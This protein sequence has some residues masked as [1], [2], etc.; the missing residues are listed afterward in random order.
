MNE[1]TKID[2]SAMCKPAAYPISRASWEDLIHCT[3]KLKIQTRSCVGRLNRIFQVL[4]HLKHVTI[5][6]RVEICCYRLRDTNMTVR[7]ASIAPSS[8]L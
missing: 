2:D 4:R 1:S 3:I 5:V 7:G 6:K 8:S